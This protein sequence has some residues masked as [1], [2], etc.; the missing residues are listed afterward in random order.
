MLSFGSN[1]SPPAP[2]PTWKPPHE[3]MLVN[4]GLIV[5]CVVESPFFNNAP[6]GLRHAAV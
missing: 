4:A 2:L 1:F 6:W 5:S 3:Q